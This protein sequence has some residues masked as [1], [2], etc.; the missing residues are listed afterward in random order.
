M[1]QEATKAAGVHP[2]RYLDAELAAH[3]PR[4][5]LTRLSLTLMSLQ[6]NAAPLMLFASEEA[7]ALSDRIRTGVGA[8]AASVLL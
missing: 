2:A 3:N 5:T 8:N 6:R 7:A 4:W 1:G